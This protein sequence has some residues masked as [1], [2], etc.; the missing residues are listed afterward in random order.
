MPGIVRQEVHK[1]KA[2]LGYIIRPCLK[3]PNNRSLKSQRIFF[4]V[5]KE[6]KLHRKQTRNHAA[7]TLFPFK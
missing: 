3:K 6:L 1:F 7:H 4:S 2:S 5:G